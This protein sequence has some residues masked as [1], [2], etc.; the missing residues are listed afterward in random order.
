MKDNFETKN[1]SRSVVKGDDGDAKVDCTVDLSGGM[2]VDLDDG[3]DEAG[4][5]AG[6]EPTEGYVADLSRGIGV[7]LDDGAVVESTEDNIVEA[8]SGADAI[9]P[10]FFLNIFKKPEDRR[11]PAKHLTIIDNN[12]KKPEIN[13]RLDAALKDF[14]MGKWKDLSREERVQAVE[15]YYDCLLEITENKN[16]PEF[17]IRD[18]PELGLYYPPLYRPPPGNKI[19][20]NQNL[21]D[22]PAKL[23]DTIAHEVWHAYQ[24]QCFHQNPF[25]KVGREYLK[26]LASCPDGRFHFFGYWMHST[27]LEARAFG[28]IFKNK[29]A[30]MKG[31]AQQ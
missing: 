13:E 29:L 9:R 10:D 4:N 6:G 1:D 24:W 30:N 25:S 7:D 15:R 20:I 22:E 27:E 5:F 16:R 11:S 14:Q 21:L 2:G 23:V 8:L 17:A 18:I 3:A 12:L 31:A 28:E 19:E 26:K